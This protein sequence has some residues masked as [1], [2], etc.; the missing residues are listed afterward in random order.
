MDRGQI[1][2]LLVE[3]MKLPCSGFRPLT[4]LSMQT[5]SCS[6]AVS[7]DLLTDARD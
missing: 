4:I 2:G 6:P 1:L 5:R 7:L 3:C